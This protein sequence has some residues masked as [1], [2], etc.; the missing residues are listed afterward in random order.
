MMDKNNNDIWFYISSVLNGNPTVEDMQHV[1]RW[2]EDKK[3]NALFHRLKDTKYNQFIEEEEGRSKEFIFIKTQA[4]IREA[5]LYTR[6]HTWKYIAAASVMLLFLTVSQLILNT[7]DDHTV[8]VESKSPA[9]GIVNLTLDDETVVALNASSTLGYPLRFDKKNRTVSL[10]GEAYFKVAKDTERPFIVETKNLKIKVLGTHFNIKSYDD[11]QKEITTLE[12]GSVSIELKHADVQNKQPVILNPGQQ[13]IL[14]KVTGETRI[15]KVEAGLYASWKDGQCFFENEKFI[16]I[17]KILERQFGVTIK[18]T[19]PNLE[20]QLYSGFFGKKDG[21]QQILNYF[22][23]YRNFDYK[24]NDTG[25]E[26][27]EK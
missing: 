17:I 9:G 23:K 10:D 20:N 6:L 26:I 19:S 14:D 21:V 4:K 7:S 24:Q 12:E 13:I 11:D 8:W 2:I 1:D 3:N 27:Y 16:D 22:K 15:C 18:I 25:I 5:N